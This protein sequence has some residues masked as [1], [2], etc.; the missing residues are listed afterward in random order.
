VNRE[1]VLR[2]MCY[3]EK[4][5]ECLSD[6]VKKRAV[7]KKAKKKDREGFPDPFFFS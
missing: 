5:T 6:W 3:V 1:E 7:G 4:V 2:V